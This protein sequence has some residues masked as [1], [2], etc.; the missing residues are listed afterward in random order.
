[1]RACRYSKLESIE[2]LIENGA[3]LEM[4]DCDSHSALWHAYDS[5]REDVCKLLVKKGANSSTK[6]P[7]SNVPYFLY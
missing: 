4:L 7:V 3:D 1:M 6:Y 5:G 2:K